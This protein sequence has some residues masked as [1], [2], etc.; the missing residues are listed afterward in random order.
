M[1]SPLYIF[2]HILLDS[3]E[4]IYAN[5]EKNDIF[6]SKLFVEKILKKFN[7]IKTLIEFTLT[8]ENQSKN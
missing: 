5:C 3:L 8:G 1:C 6:L 7:Y 4:I 2:N